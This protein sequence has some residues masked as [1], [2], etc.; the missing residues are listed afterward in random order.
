M[1]APRNH[2]NANIMG[3]P[4]QQALPLQFRS[5]AVSD[6]SGESPLHDLSNRQYLTPRWRER[7]SSAGSSVEIAFPALD[8]ENSPLQPRY[9]DFAET[10]FVTPSNRRGPPVRRNGTAS[11]LP[12]LPTDVTDNDNAI[13][14]SVP[15]RLAPRYDRRGDPFF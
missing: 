7:T 9:L 14:S 15:V 2:N 10:L 3:E 8:D 11:P 6:R 12:Y 5:L 1:L 13:A 4:S